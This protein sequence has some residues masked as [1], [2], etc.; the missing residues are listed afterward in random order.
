MSALG[1]WTPARDAFRRLDAEGRVGAIANTTAHQAGPDVHRFGWFAMNEAGES[2]GG[3]SPTPE[4]AR[5]DADAALVELG[6]AS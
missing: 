2:R 3:S 6:A 4:Q 1:P 5:A